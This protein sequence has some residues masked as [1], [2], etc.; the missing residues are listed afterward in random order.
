MNLAMMLVLQIALLEASWV[1][2]GDAPGTC[3]PL[4]RSAEFYIND[5]YF[6]N[7]SLNNETWSFLDERK[8]T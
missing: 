4:D 7:P 1:F 5:L 8:I 6:F 3:C 2:L